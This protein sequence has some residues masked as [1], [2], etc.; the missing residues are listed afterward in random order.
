MNEH[1]PFSLPPLPYAYSALE[2]QISGE[3]LGYHHDKHFA[4]YVDNLNKALEPY[5]AFH[6]W[7]L[8]KLVRE[9]GSLPLEIA[10]AVRNNA[11]GVYNHTCYFA[12][13]T[14][15]QNSGKPDPVLEAQLLLVFGTLEHFQKKFKEAALGQFGSGYAWLT[16]DD[17]G[18]LSIEKTANQDAPFPRHPLLT[19]DVWEHAYYLDYQNRRA[20]YFDTWWRLV[21]WNQ[22]SKCY[23]DLRAKLHLQ[24]LLA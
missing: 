22:V 11:G 3:T 10:A 16:A 9:Y 13:L 24:P 23:A 8:E 6:D 2:E 14:S 20:D 15:A 7:P 19:V 1:Y 4:A 5:P 21:D 12:N 17:E 18:T